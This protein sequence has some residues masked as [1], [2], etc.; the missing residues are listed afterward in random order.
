MKPRITR[1]LPGAER[2]DAREPIATHS[3]IRGPLIEARLGDGP[4]AGRTVEVAA[5]EGRPPKTIDI[6]RPS[7]ALSRYCLAEW[8]QSGHSADYTF[9]YDV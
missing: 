3:D 1:R 9:L 4:L 7:G 5:V 6:T 8:Q 2:T